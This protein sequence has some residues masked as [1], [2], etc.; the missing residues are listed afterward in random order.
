MSQRTYTI[1]FAV[2]ISIW[3]LTFH[4]IVNKSIVHSS[5]FLFQRGRYILTCK[6][7]R[8]LA[9]QNAVQTIR[10]STDSRNSIISLQNNIKY[11]LFASEATPIPGY[12]ARNVLLI[13]LC[14]VAHPLPRRNSFPLHVNSPPTIIRARK[15]RIVIDRQ[16]I[17]QRCTL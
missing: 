15:L 17:K 5:L 9:Y 8:K 10:L 3:K 14:R 12:S 2:I 16:T 1:L 6:S 11:S 13:S 4:Q 7:S